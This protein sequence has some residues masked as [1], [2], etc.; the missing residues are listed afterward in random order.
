MSRSVKQN[1]AMR[2]A[3]RRAII[4]SAMTLFAQNGYAHTTTRSIAEEAGISVGLMYHYFDG[5][6]GLLHAV[7]EHAMTILDQTF[8][9]VYTNSAPNERLAALLRAMFDLLAGDESFWSLFYMLRTQPAIMH[10]LR[11]DFLTWTARLRDLFIDELSQAGHADP[12][13]DA[14]LLYSLVEGTI[15][16]YLLDPDNYPL[17]RVVAE[18]ISQYGH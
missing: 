1:E 2:S 15:Q 6:E 8:T 14:L 4:R 3:A 16:Q 18:I 9:A 13:L 10:V 17:E 5:K 12:V 11:N 7:F